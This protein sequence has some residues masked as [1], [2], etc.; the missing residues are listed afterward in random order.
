[1]KD[2]IYFWAIYW[3]LPWYR[4]IH[5]QSHKLNMDFPWHQAAHMGRIQ[6]NW[7]FH[8]PTESLVSGTLG[9]LRLAKDP[10]RFRPTLRFTF[11]SQPTAQGQ[12]PYPSF[13]QWLTL[14]QSQCYGSEVSTAG[15][16]AKGS[17]VK[18]QSQIQSVYSHDYFQIDREVGGQLSPFQPVAS[19]LKPTYLFIWNHT[20]WTYIF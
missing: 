2:Y 4:H 9:Y 6:V 15:K 3:S 1:M 10:R 12:P 17:D 8:F 11:L 5:T 19:T 16:L 7:N 13:S 14:W 18:V 20:R